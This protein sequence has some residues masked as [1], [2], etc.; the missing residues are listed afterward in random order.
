M[1]HAQIL[2]LTVAPF[3]LTACAASIAG[4]VQK[5]SPAMQEPCQA[6]VVLPLRELSQSEAEVFWGRDR[7]SLRNCGERY[8]LLLEFINAQADVRMTR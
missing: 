2:T 8:G 3:L 6:A 7:T 5:P 1:K 4:D